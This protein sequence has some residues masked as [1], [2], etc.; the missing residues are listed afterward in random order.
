MDDLRPRD[1]SEYIGQDKMKDRLDTYCCDAR[2][3]QRPLPHVLLVG[4]AGYGKTSM[5]ALLADQMHAPFHKIT[6]SPATKPAVLARFFN[7]FEGGVVLFD[8][9]HRAPT[10][11]QEELLNPLE[12]GYFTTPNG[13][14]IF[15]PWF[16]AI[17][18]T[19][20]KQ[21]VLG[22]II[23]RVPIQ[24]TFDPYTEAELG[25]IF[26]GMARRLGFELDPDLAVGL[27]RAAGGCPRGG[28]SMVY[29]ARA[30]T[31]R[32]D[33]TLD[34]ILEFCEVDADGVTKDHRR[35]MAAIDK[36]AG[37]GA[38]GLDRLSDYLGVHPAVIRD[39]ERLLTNLDLI[40]YGAGGREL[41]E[42]GIARIRPERRTFS[43]AA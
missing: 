33:L 20:E 26:E 2:V 38:V 32:G 15:L 22:T 27:G 9:V 1:W 34:A 18:A 43:G 30:L 14:K 11:L 16:T 3:D 35:L 13:R 41:S 28:L 7:R 39:L 21:D 29:A 24:P 8:E 4:R 31:K 36:L 25:T 12:D 37:V 19:T 17:L 23:D 42:A 6:L 10:N 5:A 40:T